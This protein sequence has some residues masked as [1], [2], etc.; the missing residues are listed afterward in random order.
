M[1]FLLFSF[2]MSI[3]WI[4]ATAQLLIDLLEIFGLLTGLPNNLLALT[5]L[6][7]GNSVGD[8][9]AN[10]SIA[11]KGFAEMALTGCF[12]AP[13]FNNVLGLGI[14][15]LKS[16]YITG[17]VIECSIED[18]HARIPMTM[19]CGNFLTL[20]LVMLT[21]ICNGSHLSKIQ[22]FINI[23]IYAGIIVVIVVQA[24]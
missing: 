16:N 9:I 7:W 19:I 3:F 23:I 20:F 5:I 10:T 1:F 17:D 2:A 12:A 22:A 18:L 4:W 24:L 15:I 21:T 13:L 14:T 6:A 11:K 8:F